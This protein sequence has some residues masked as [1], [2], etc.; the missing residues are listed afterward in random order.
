MLVLAAMA[1]PLGC[2]GF[3]AWNLRGCATEH[4]RPVGHN[5]ITFDV[6]PDGRALAFAGVGDGGRDLFLLDLQSR[7]VTPLTSS[8]DYE[9]GPSF[10]RD[11]KSLAFTRGTPGVRADQLYVMELSTRKVVQLTNADENVSSP[12]FLPD[13]KRV[14]CT[15]EKIYR[16]GGLASSWDEG[17][18]L[19]VIDIDTRKQTPL[20]TRRRPVF[21]PRVS[22][23]GKWIAWIDDGGYV[24]PMSDPLK[25]SKVVPQAA[26]LAINT[27]GTKIAASI[28]EYSPDLKIYL[29]DRKGRSRRIISGTAKGCNDPVFSPD[30]EYVYFS[31][32]AWLEGAT[33]VPTK[34]L[35]RAKTSGRE[36][37]DIATYQL[38]ENPLT[39]SRTAPR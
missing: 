24:A 32:E 2:V 16:W 13:G 28:G 31:A 17:G 8:E 26:T 18:E 27:D 33:G 36:V 7:R 4:S 9:I 23:D 34:S 3:A 25:A 20:K 22:S 12:V 11:G 30:G 6:S 21:S 5:D 29:T 37:T 14:L 19:R 39:Y 10:S 38:F 1:C 35:M 15:V